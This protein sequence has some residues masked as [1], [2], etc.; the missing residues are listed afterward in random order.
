MTSAILERKKQLEAG[1]SIYTLPLRVCFYARVSTDKDQ[2]LNSLGSQCS[3]FEDFIKG[4]DSW[5]FAG[6]YIDEGI[7]GK[8]TLR[9]TNF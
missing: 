4:Q 9:R 5:Q 1:K 3:Y 7:S 2:Q 8:C 6:G